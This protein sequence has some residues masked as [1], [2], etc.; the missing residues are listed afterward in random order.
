MMASQI[1]AADGVY[2]LESIVRG[3]HV[4]KRI[5][6]THVVEQ[7]RLKHEENNENDQRAVAVLKIVSL[8]AICYENRRKL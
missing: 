7:I 5:W 8:S 4:Y 6:T 2:V 3:H 1:A